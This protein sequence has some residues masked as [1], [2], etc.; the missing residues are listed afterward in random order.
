MLKIRNPKP[1]I[2]I[3][4]QASNPKPEIQIELN[5]LHVSDL[6]IGI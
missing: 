3:K 4:L 6:D 1:E 5:R 2:R